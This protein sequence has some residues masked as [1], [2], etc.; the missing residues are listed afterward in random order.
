[1]SAAHPGDA[2]VQGNLLA[3]C[4]RARDVAGFERALETAAAAGL[5]GPQMMRAAPAFR[6]AMVEELRAHK[7][8]DG[9][10]LLPVSIIAKLGR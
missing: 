3:A 8:R 1:M 2:R 7:A 10:H 6:Q 4:Y 5:S 9:S